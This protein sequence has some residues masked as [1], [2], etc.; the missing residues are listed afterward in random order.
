MQRFCVALLLAALS[1][2]AA[3]AWDRVGVADDGTVFYADPAAIQTSGSEVKMWV[4]LDYKTAQKSDSG[5][6]YL[7]AKLLHE[8]DCQGERGRTRY[9][10][11]HAGH[12]GAGT[13]VYSEVRPASE[14]RPARR[15]IIGET[16][17]KI[18]CGR[19]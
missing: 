17:W 4:L 18:A 1:A 15:E 16:L 8:Y 7:S 12:M 3:A 14:W 11:L 2:G 13:L 5:K 10:S 9:F 19:K 6:E